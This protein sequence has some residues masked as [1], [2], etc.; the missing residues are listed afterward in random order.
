[1]S[2]IKLFPCPFCGSEK[3]K[4]ESKN[5][6]IHYHEKDGMREWQNVVFSVRCNSCHARG[7]TTSADLPTMGIY[8]DLVSKKNDAIERAIRAW[9]TRKPIDDMV[10]QLDKASDYY[11]CDEQG[12]EHVQMVDLSEAIDIVRGGRE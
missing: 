4:L 8:G 5:G 9:N 7:S 2:E 11:E 6:R 12:R 3:L 1:M 10:E